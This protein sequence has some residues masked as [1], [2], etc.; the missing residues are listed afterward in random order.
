MEPRRPAPPLAA[1][2]A[3]APLLLVL[4]MP[5]LGLRLGFSDEGNYP[6]AP[7]PGRPTTCWPRASGPASTARCCSWPSCPRAPI[8]PSSSA[9]PTPWPPPRASPSPPRPSPTTPR[10]RP[11][12]L[13]RVIPTTAPQDEATTDLVDRLRDD[14]LPAVDD[15][16]GLD[17]AVTGSVAVQ[18]DFSDYIAARLPL[19]FGAVLTLSFLLLMVVFRS[20]LVPLKAVVMNLLS[21]GAAYGVVVAVFQWGWARAAARLRRAPRSSRS[22]R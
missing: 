17:V 1:G 4:A 18:V 7:T 10:T 5:V 2:S 14:V 21:I 20:I 11:R 9:S 16:T 15:G 12:S 8:P 3:A 13:W 6:E 19:F 22:C